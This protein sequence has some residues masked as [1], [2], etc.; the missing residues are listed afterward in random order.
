[1]SDRTDPERIGDMIQAR[2]REAIAVLGD[3][4]FTEFC[5]D[6]HYNWPSFIW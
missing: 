1:M 5:A 3:A 2:Q 6:R 4:D